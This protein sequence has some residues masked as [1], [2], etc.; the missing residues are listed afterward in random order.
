MFSFLR[1]KASSGEAPGGDSR[2]FA[3]R[4]HRF[5]LF[6][7]AWNNFQD[8][9]TELEY[10]L[11]C[12]HPFGMNRVRSLCTQTATQVFQC[13]MQI[14]K[15]SPGSG[16]VPAERFGILQNEVSALVFPK[17]RCLLGPS[18][19]AVGDPELESVPEL[20][21]PAAARLGVLQ[22]SMPD[23]VPP[24]FVLTA[25][26]CE[27]ILRENDLQEEISRRV[28][29]AGGIT[30][31]T[32]LELAN[33]LD[34]LINGASM[35]A[36]LTDDLGRE[37]ERL[38]RETAGRDMRLIFRGRMWPGSGNGP[39]MELDH[40]LVLWGPSLPLNS[41]DEAIMAALRSTIALKYHAPALVYKRYRGL[42]D[43]GAGMC[44]ACLCVEEGASGGVAHTGNPMSPVSF[45]SGNV[46]LYTG[47]GLP[48][49]IEYS[50][51]PVDVLHVSRSHPHKVRLR[52][53]AGPAGR[54]GPDDPVLSD[55]EAVRIAE[56]SLSLENA[57]NCRRQSVTFALEPSGGLKVL[58]QRAMIMGHVEDAEVIPA[59]E[60]LPL[61]LLAGGV[62]ASPGI[63]CGKPYILKDLADMADFPLGGLLVVERDLYQWTALMDRACGIVAES[64]ILASRLGS[65]AREFGKPAIFGMQGAVEQLAGQ[66]CVTVY[67]DGCLVYPGRVETLL[68][69]AQPPRD[70]MPQSPVLAILR[71][72]AEHILP[73][74]LTL[75]PDSPDFTA[76]SCNTYHDI[77]RFCHEK[78]V[79]AMFDFGSDH[80]RAASRVKQLQDDVLKQFWVVN[81]DDGFDGPINGP[82]VHIS[83]IKSKP[84]L[85]LWKGMNAWAWQGP[86]AVN[87][88]GF[89]SVLFE[90]T[91]NPHLDPATQS[92]FFTEKNYFMIAGDYCSLHSRF[93][94]HFVSVEARITE[95]QAENYVLFRLRGGAANIERRVARVNFVGD[96]L[97]EFG[98][99]PK[100]SSDAV[101]AR[102]ENISPEEG[103]ALLHVAGH[104]CIHTRQLD[105]IMADPA[106]VAARRREL[107]ARC[108]ELY[109][110]HE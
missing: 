60:E 86:P 96:I 31:S 30:A 92:T 69:L 2:V 3:A 47:R 22:R 41:D 15:L 14:D 75:D 39:E 79:Q 19:I 64:G 12:D 38:R 95:R 5:K 33:S 1:P 91:A 20:V 104:M 67:G 81:L 76:A 62:A 10:V 105:M 94:F 37:L 59:D 23:Y 16:K 27:Q 53:V 42:T 25:A 110:A 77:G 7:T 72:A 18:I 55:E 54:T 83:K 35:P 56:L 36:D 52:N 82:V 17:G 24:G 11:C 46:H 13:I 45:T 61:P 34:A 85:A 48:E 90:A 66:E 84:M 74:N 63:C 100:I 89:M 58:M 93:G 8:V 28:Q 98:F 109:V 49:D 101:A 4:H 78:A 65:L 108:R 88:K 21:D 102:A 107:I 32:A 87:G 9:M 70:F 6:L 51:L 99:T 106:E 29:I 26:G 68:E 71:H 43:L 50:L 97:W 73:L 44:V 80:R 57:G 40:G 103:M